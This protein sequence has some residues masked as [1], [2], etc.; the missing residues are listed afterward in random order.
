MSRCLLRYTRPHRGRFARITVLTLAASLL[1]ALQPWPLKLVADHV[2]GHEALS[3]ALAAV[4]GPAGLNANRMGLL[5]A[6]AVGGL[7]L[8]L[9]NAL[10]DFVLASTWTFVGR[11][12]V[13]DLAEELFGLLQRRSLAF[14]ARQSVGDTMS[15]ITRDSWCVWQCVDQVLFAPAHGLLTVAVMV[16]LMAR[17]DPQLTLLAVGVA[18]LMV[19]AAFLIGKPLHLAAKLKREI[20]GRIAAHLQQTLTGIPVVQAFAQEG[21][22]EERF[23]RFAADAV[24]VQQRGAVLASINSLASGLVATL[25]A[26]VILW[27]GARHVLDHRLTLGSLLVFLV[28]L[29]ALQTQVKAFAGSHG[30]WRAVSPSFERVA[31]LLE[32][33]P[34][35]SDAPGA[36]TLP[37]PRGRITLEHVSFA[38][39]PGQPVLR[40]LS[41]AVEPGET[42]AIVGSTGAG[43]S[44]LAALIPRL[45]DPQAGAVRIDGRDVR[46]LKVESLRRQVGLVLQEPFLFPVSVGENI[47]YGRPEATR[48]EVEAAARAAHAHEFITRLPGGY[49]AIPGERG[50]TL[51]GGERQRLAI[52]RAVLKDAPILI[53]DEPSSALDAE[54]EALVLAALERLRAGR[55]SLFI[56]HRLSTVRRVDRILVLREG[57]ITENGS[58]EELLRRGGFYAHLHDIQFRAR[59][60]E[61]CLADPTG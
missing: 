7:L 57:R 60:A 4:F 55:S 12:M 56:A 48:A 52:A 32:A 37:R 61:S 47:A 29:T 23:R 53:L 5:A 14:H 59:G 42:V 25:G 3:G 34:E 15:C 10:V 9:A 6:A 20:E 54:T 22:E 41:L 11:R 50:L 44:T 38:Y 19:G 27:I 13:H 8:F 17:L 28:Y 51:S 24:R 58:H 18:P 43:K 16:V 33:A 35:I 49:D 21:R 39:L 1:A 30:A 31:E 36:T 45:F 40:D 26:G 46:A 2:L